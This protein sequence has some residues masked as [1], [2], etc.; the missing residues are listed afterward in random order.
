LIAAVPDGDIQI[1]GNKGTVTNA[2]GEKRDLTPE[3]VTAVRSKQKDDR[4]QSK[5]KMHQ[6]TIDNNAGDDSQMARRRTNRAKQ[7]ILK[8]DK[9]IDKEMEAVVQQV[10][11]VTS[12]DDNAL[13]GP[14]V[15]PVPGDLKYEKVYGEVV[16]ELL[17]RTGS[18][19]N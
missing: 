12:R 14:R 19:E 17:H 11:P 8:I 7:E 2:A 1:G 15:A 16:S 10:A 18:Q 5:R 13:G 6:E 4:R 3:E 9:E